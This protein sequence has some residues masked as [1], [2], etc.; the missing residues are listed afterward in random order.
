MIPLALPF[1]FNP[2]SGAALAAAAEYVLAA[3]VGILLGV[4]VY[5]GGKVLSEQIS[6][7]DA[8]AKTETKD[9]VATDACS[10]CE[11]PGCDS[12]IQRMDEKNRSFKKEVDKYDPIEDAKGGHKYWAR[13]VERITKPGGHYQEIRELQRGL[14]KDLVKFNQKEC[15]KS[16]RQNAKST[17]DAAQKNVNREIGPPPGIPFIPL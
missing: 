8:D 16:G 9:A 10:T 7:A 15:A 2:A 17:R 13:G 14:K 11:P 4:G 1:F 3:A 6:K 5:E 12:I